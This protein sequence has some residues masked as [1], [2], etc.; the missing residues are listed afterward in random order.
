M[1][2]N[3]LRFIRI[4]V[5]PR[6][7]TAA[8]GKGTFPEALPGLEHITSEAEFVAQLKAAAPRGELPPFV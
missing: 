2:S 4:V 6:T 5:R 7:D 3:R 1:L 8:T